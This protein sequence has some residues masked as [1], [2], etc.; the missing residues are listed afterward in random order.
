MLTFS[1]VTERQ[2][3]VAIMYYHPNCPDGGNF[4]KA[5]WYYLPPFGG[6]TVF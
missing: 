5:G 4:S 2:T 6:V 1:N 3:W